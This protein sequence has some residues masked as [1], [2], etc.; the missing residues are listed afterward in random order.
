MG[1]N[2]K[3]KQ[4]SRPVIIQEGNVNVISQP[5]KPNYTRE[6]INRAI[7]YVRGITNSAEERKWTMNFHNQH[8]SDKQ[9]PTC[10]SCWE[11]VKTRM[12]HL[13][14]KLSFYEQYESSRKTT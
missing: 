2:C 1:C 8:F 10:S 11:R 12:E 13:E 14:Q 5:S 6:E 9:I 4:S 3:Q 7:N